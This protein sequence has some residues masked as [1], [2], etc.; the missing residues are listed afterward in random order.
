MAG[1]CF[2]KKLGWKTA[3]RRKKNVC[4]INKLELGKIQLNVSVAVA[5]ALIKWKE[6]P[7]WKKYNLQGLFTHSFV[8]FRYVN[9]SIHLDYVS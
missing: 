8:H 9:Y 2:E 3:E 1:L 5:V 7:A 6:L 4:P